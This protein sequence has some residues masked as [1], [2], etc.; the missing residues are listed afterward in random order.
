MWI[1]KLCLRVRG[2]RGIEILDIIG[3]MTGGGGV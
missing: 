1:L 3:L 2:S